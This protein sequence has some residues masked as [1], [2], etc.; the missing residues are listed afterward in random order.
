MARLITSHALVLVNARLPEFAVPIECI[1]AS[2][3][4]WVAVRQWPLLGWLGK[5][6]CSRSFA[7]TQ[8]VAKSVAG[9]YI[10]VEPPRLYPAG[11]IWTWPMFRHAK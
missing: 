11:Q 8:L 7:G 3:R 1:E 6:V 10:W 2:A 9:S 4:L 5:Y